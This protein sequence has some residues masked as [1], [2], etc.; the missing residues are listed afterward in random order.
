MKPKWTVG[1]V[2]AL[3]LAGISFAAYRTKI[4]E[5]FSLNSFMSS[6]MEKGAAYINSLSEADLQQWT[7]RTQSLIEEFSPDQ[8]T[9]ELVSGE[10]PPDLAQLGIIRVDIAPRS[11]RYV[12][13]GGMDHTDLLVTKN[14]AGLFEI[15]ANFND[16]TPEVRLWPR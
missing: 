4:H 8:A 2:V 6:Q 15:H 3:T 14:D 12:W 16:E 7:V 5:V 9:I 10:I 11:V 13:L 1:L